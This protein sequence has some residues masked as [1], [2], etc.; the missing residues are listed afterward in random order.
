MNNDG[1]VHT[2]SIQKLIDAVQ[3]Y[4]HG[5]ADAGNILQDASTLLKIEMTNDD[6]S[7]DFANKMDTALSN[8]GES[9]FPKLESL[10]EDLYKEKIK[11]DDV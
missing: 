3:E 7:K 2:E 11:W 6:V 4:A 9:V 5:I 1:T 10:V 8:L